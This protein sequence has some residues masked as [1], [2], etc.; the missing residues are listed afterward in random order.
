M[1]VMS[2]VTKLHS[3]ILEALK[4][5]AEVAAIMADAYRRAR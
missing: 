1:F 4:V 2:L 5:R 3:A